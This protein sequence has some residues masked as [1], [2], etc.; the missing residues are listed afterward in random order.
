MENYQAY[1]NTTV[2]FTVGLNIIIGESDVGKSSILRAL[3]KLVRDI[4]A[5]KDFINED[6][7]ST[8]LSLTIVDDNDQEHTIIRQ[9]TPSK[10][11]YY[12][13]EH[14]FGGFGREIPEE[15]Q[16]TVEMVLVEL[17]NDVK[18]DLHFSDQHDTP[19]MIARGSAGT[20]S[21]LLGR[22]AGLHILDRGIVAVNKDIRTGNSA[23]NHKSAD[24][25]QL[26]RNV[27]ESVDTMNGHIL[28]DACKGQLSEIG[29]ELKA[30]VKLRD[31]QE[32]FLEIIDAGKKTKKI[33][34]NIPE[35]IADFHEMREDIRQ[36]VKLQ[37][38]YTRLNFIEQQI[39]SLPSVEFDDAVDFSE[40]R[41][42]IQKLNKFQKSCKTLDIIEDQIKL[43]EAMKFDVDIEKVQKE[44][45][46]LLTTLKICPV[47][48]QSTIHIGEHCGQS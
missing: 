5:G 45:M 26:Q 10:N 4:P 15:I 42:N 32:L 8:K 16:N 7:V 12:L 24:R 48:K 39:I 1:K 18:I 40:I 6:A 14:E 22:I 3:R 46:E 2:N 34:D 30:L 17:E 29:E 21:K 47:C 43:L 27:D 13:D 41:E 20:R 36:L 44:R 33:L 38:F 35:I 31:L 11:L 25:D 28:Y 19:F 9:I 37:E 23:L